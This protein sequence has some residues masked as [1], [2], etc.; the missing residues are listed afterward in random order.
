MPLPFLLRRSWESGGPSE[1][2][3]SAALCLAALE[4]TQPIAGALTLPYRL[5]GS[6]KAEVD[7]L[8]AHAGSSDLWLSVP[9][10]VQPIAGA[11]WGHGCF[12]TAPPEAGKLRAFPQSPPEAQC[13]MSLRPG[14]RTAHCRAQWE[15]WRFRTTQ[16]EVGKPSGLF[17]R[18]RQG[19]C[20]MS[21]RSGNR[22]AHCRGAGASAP[23]RREWEPCHKRK[24]RRKFPPL[25]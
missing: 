8:S 3:G 10:T 22:M 6:G 9:K 12:R 23:S 20:F 19:R 5:T 24:K 17:P 15:R 25:F 7:F 16:P 11:Q 13:F 1:P 18:A 4:A 14:N 21:L 2:A